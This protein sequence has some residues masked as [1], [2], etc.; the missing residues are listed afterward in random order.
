MLSND[1]ILVTIAGDYFPI[2]RPQI[3]FLNGMRS[4]DF[5]VGSLKTLFSGSDFN[6]VNLECPLSKRGTPIFKFGPNYRGNPEMIR[7]LTYL[8]VSGVTMANNHIRDFG[9]VGIEDTLDLCLINHIKTVGAGITLEEARSPLYLS[10][11]GRRVAFVNVAEQEFS[12]ALSTRAG[13]NPLDLISLLTDLQKARNQ[14]DHIILIIHGGLEFTHIPSPQ[15][16]RL[17]RFLAEQD[18][19]AVIRHHSHFV[20]GYEVWKG[21]PIFYG[22][23]NML[24]DSETPMQ[25][26]W[27]EGLIVKL[28][29]SSENTCFF[30]LYPIRQCK[31]TP[32]VK[33]LEGEERD[34]AINNIK[35]YSNMLADEDELI[36]AWEEVLKT[37]SDDYFS[38]LIISSYT[39]RRI[40]GRFGLM[41]FF[42]PGERSA[43]FLENF[44]RCETHREVLLDI[45]VS[46][47]SNKTD[48]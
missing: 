22:L 5:I 40:V 18:V 4:S 42:K 31:E 38:M 26:G 14:A 28:C 43:L 46:R 19:T 32:S 7:L 13:A 47:K 10:I 25:E 24:F 12:N 2:G 11:K 35:E 21:V 41:K 20:Q 44:L 30:E 16:V 6:M 45:L 3:E 9:D 36:R 23:G 15:S 17:L 34:L 1:K 39:L 48:K 27:Y 37:L 33:L 29:I 8:G